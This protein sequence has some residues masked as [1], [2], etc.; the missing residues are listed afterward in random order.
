[1]FWAGAALVAFAAASAA[2]EPTDLLVTFEEFDPALF[3]TPIPNEHT[4]V[5]D[6][7]LWTRGGPETGYPP[8]VF[9]PVRGRDLAIS[10]R[11]RQLGDG[12]YV[13][14]LV[15]GDDGFGGEDHQF[16]VK[17]LRDGVELQ[18]DGH[19]LDAED[20]AIQKFGGPRIDPV[21]GSYRTNELFPRERLDLS[22]DGWRQVQIVFSDDTAEVSLADPPW[23]TSIQRPGLR[24]AKTKLL[25]ML[26]GGAAGIELDD[27]R[28]QPTA[29]LQAAERAR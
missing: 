1:M 28:V 13:W 29:S 9:L 23:S 21:S 15:D 16:R 12:E 18:V 25:W 24:H 27:I 14:L 8:M 5:R 2:D 3:Q 11:Y 6:G 19:T 17:L 4:V 26:K 20:P 22:G 10:F 7:A